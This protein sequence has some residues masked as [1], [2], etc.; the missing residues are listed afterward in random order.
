MDVH[1]H[2]LAEYLQ[3]LSTAE[4]NEKKAHFATQ[5]AYQLN[6]EGDYPQAER[7]AQDA[8][9][10]ALPTQQGEAYYQLARA[11]FMQE[12]VEGLLPTIEQA[13]TTFETHNQLESV[14][15]CYNMLGALYTNLHTYDKALENFELSIEHNEKTQNNKEL[16]RVFAHL[17]IFVRLAMPAKNILIF[18][19]NLLE[20]A[21]EARKAFIH[22]NLG[23]FYRQ[24][25]QDAKA[26]PEFQQALSLKQAENIT[27]Q[28]AETSYNLAS[29][30][31]LRG[32][33]ELAYHFYLAA[34]GQSLQESK[35]ERIELIL[36]YLSHAVGDIQ[37]EALQRHTYEL[38]AKAQEKGY[39]IA[40]EESA[41][42]NEEVVADYRGEVMAQ[43]L[44]F[45]DKLAEVAQLEKSFSAEEL[46]KRY[47]ETKDFEIGLIWLRKLLN[48]YNGAWFNRKAKLQ[49]Y[50]DAKATLM[51]DLSN[52]L[53]STDLSPEDRNT[54]EKIQKSLG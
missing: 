37:D 40:S 11:F 5:I 7:Y 16:G 2:S 52:A 42:Q 47:A 51:Q 12:N 44:N 30:H 48:Q 18:Y 33:S 31:D 20:G 39:G 46:G 34:L 10:Y 49:L 1:E 6:E 4:T 25:Q 21:T 43:D 35:P 23:V 29:L 8:L 14:G 3:A 50:A 45:T 28:L 27:Y 36:Y 26:L 13:K 19:Q 15:K 54:L 17:T 38:M 41:D 24:E 22:H 32:E 9:K 53:A